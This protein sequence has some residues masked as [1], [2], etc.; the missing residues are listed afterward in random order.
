MFLYS[1][2]VSEPLAKGFTCTGFKKARDCS[3]IAQILA[4]A[5]AVAPTMRGAT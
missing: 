1:Y 3:E 4:A 5:A 2:G